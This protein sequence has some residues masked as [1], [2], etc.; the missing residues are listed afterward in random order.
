[1]EFTME[2]IAPQ[3]HPARRPII[4]GL[5]VV[6]ATVVAGIGLAFATGMAQPVMAKAFTPLPPCCTPLPVL[7]DLPAPI[8]TPTPLP[9]CCEVPRDVDVPSDPP[10]PPAPTPLPPCCT[11]V[12]PDVPTPPTPPAPTPLPPCCTDV[13]PTP[14]PPPPV[15]PP[16]V[17]P[18]VV[19]PPPPPPSDDDERCVYLNISKTV[20]TTP[21][22]AVVL[23]WKYE[24]ASSITIS[25]VGSFSTPQGSVTVYPTQPTTYVATVPGA[26][27][28]SDCQKSVRLE[29]EPV[30]ED[31]RCVY[32]TAN[33]TDIDEGDEVRLSW[34]TRN[35]DYTTINEGIGRVTPTDEGSITVRPRENTTYRASVPGD[36]NNADCVVRITVD[37]D[38]DRDRDRDRDRPDVV[39][40]SE[41]RDAE[42]PLGS[43]YLSEM[44]YTGLDLGPFGTFLYWMMIVVW[45]AAAAYLVLFGGL[46]ALRRRF[47]TFGA[48]VRESLA[49][50]PAS[51]MMSE[52]SVPVQHDVMH[53]AAVAAAMPAV[54][55]SRTELTGDGFK[56]FASAD[57]LTIDDIVKGLS[58][59]SG[60]NISSE[61]A[62][63]EPA[64]EY[65]APAPVERAEAPAPRAAVADVHPEVPGF[66]AAI[67]EGQ[68]DQVFGLIR[69]LNQAG[70]DVE[71][72]MAHAICALDDAYRARIDGTPVHAE[73]K[74]ATD[75]CATSFLERLV[76]ALTT[77]VDGS[78]S[79]GV[80]GIKLALTRALAVSQG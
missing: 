33:R 42:P 80:T 24:D 70:H 38:D 25:G 75:H 68:R 56:R 13:P 71:S 27:A 29:R 51:M 32:L 52:T 41:R 14:V 57:A 2:T 74:R 44:P 62:P 73:V 54:A 40:D 35:A 69:E 19:P 11:E 67:L 64:P 1:M 76:S 77:A 79:M 60:M 47:A 23:T 45:S 16:V 37:E 39:F 49:P 5:V 8:P 9:P 59:E 72:F 12:P 36:E 78:Y 26:P 66:I 30:T 6:L 55:P 65:V 61:P 34:K 50:A 10:T 17:P 48:D 22:E 58:R 18:P 15:E 31:A 3:A 21:G 43:V 20:I 53:A 46:P 7:P 28:N 4:I 63:V